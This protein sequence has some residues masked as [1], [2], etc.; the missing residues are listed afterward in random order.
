MFD[1][2]C[3]AIWIVLLSVPSFIISNVPGIDAPLA[4]PEVVDQFAVLFHVDDDD[5]IQYLSAEKAQYDIK[6]K[7]SSGT[8]F[9]MAVF[10]SE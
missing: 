4:P 9:S 10:F 6:I 7:T 5:E 2:D 8:V 3:L 1:D